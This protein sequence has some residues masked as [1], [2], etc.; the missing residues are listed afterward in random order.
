MK[1]TKDLEER[2]VNA[3]PEVLAFLKKQDAKV[4]HEL[5]SDLAQ[6]MLGMKKKTECDAGGKPC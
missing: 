6:R 4:R 1:N 2:A 3:L 5:L